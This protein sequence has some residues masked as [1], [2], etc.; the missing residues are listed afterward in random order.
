MA[1][2]MET[3]TSNGVQAVEPPVSTH[4][5]V[6]V[7]PG[8]PTPTPQPGNGEEPPEVPVPTL[9]EP[10]EPDGDTPQGRGGFHA[11]M[12]TLVGNRMPWGNKTIQSRAH[13]APYGRP[14]RKAIFSHL[15]QPQPPLPQ[16]PSA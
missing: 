13:V 9:E 3:M 12:K 4:T 7:P 6:P 8:E 16:Q 1:M 2:V 15:P 11:R 14:P 5:S 10:A